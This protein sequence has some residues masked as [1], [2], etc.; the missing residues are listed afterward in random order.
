MI[1]KRTTACPM[2]DPFVCRPVQTN[3][4]LP[5]IANSS[6][7]SDAGP[8]AEQQEAAERQHITVRNPRQ[9]RAGPVEVAVAQDD[10]E[11]RGDGHVSS[12]WRI[13]ARVS[14]CILAGRR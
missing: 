6:A 12:R 8:A 14:P 1:S 5:N 4:D 11:R 9:A 13:A 3:T 7:G 10:P 2:P